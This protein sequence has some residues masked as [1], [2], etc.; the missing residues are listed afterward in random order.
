MNGN[1]RKERGRMVRIEVLEFEY[2][3]LGE[4]LERAVEYIADQS[5]DGLWLECHEELAKAFARR[6]VELKA[7]LDALDQQHALLCERAAHGPAE[8]IDTHRRIRH[9]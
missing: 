4:E 3:A 8:W 9:T 6:R 7:E 5:P 2:E 1:D